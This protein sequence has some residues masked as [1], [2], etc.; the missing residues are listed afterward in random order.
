ML[1]PPMMAS[2]VAPSIGSLAAQRQVVRQVC[3][4]EDQLQ[5]ADEMRAAQHDEAAVAQRLSDRRGRRH[6]LRKA[7]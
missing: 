4:Y 2:A 7:A 1:M 3:V 6:A 5:P